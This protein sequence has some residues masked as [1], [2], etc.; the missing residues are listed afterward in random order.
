[1]PKPQCTAQPARDRALQPG[2][3]QPRSII[4]QGAG[5]KNVLVHGA[6]TAHLALAAGFLDELEI[7][8]VPVLLGQGRRLFDHLGP[9]HIETGAYSGHR[10]DGVTHLHYVVQQAPSE[11]LYSN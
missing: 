10:G 3:R 8:L 6:A 11:T 1:M 7:H 5:D 4:A 2:F 9:E